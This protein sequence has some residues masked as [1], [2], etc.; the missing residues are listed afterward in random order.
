MGDYESRL[1]DIQCDINH[2]IERIN[3][4]DPTLCNEKWRGITH[5]YDMGILEFVYQQI[6]AEDMLDIV[7]D[8]ICKEYRTLFLEGKIKPFI[9]NV[10][11]YPNLDEPRMTLQ[12]YAD[13]RRELLSARRDEQEARARYAQKLME[14]KHDAWKRTQNVQVTYFLDGTLDVD[15]YEGRLA[16]QVED[17]LRENDTLLRR[18]GEKEEEIKKLK[19]E[20]ISNFPKE[21]EKAFN[22]RTGKPCFTNKQMGIFLRAIAQ[23]TEKPNPPAKTKLG[24]VVERIAGYNAT[25]VNQNMKGDTST[26]DKKVVAEAIVSCLPNLAAQVWKV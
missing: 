13:R 9:D 6:E 14:R 11:G 25:T 17:V 19:S 15:E 1:F 7:T 20:L 18:L 8:L 23:I 22:T 10:S 12:S 16:D 21:P 3:S 5:D 24:E 4:Y 26:N 2:L